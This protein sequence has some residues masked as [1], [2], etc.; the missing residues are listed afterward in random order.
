MNKVLLFFLAVCAPSVITAFS[1]IQHQSFL[2]SASSQAAG[3]STSL[4]AFFKGKEYNKV[5]EN[6]MLTKGLTREEAEQDYNAYLE[7]PTN[8]ALSKV[9]TL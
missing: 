4:N 8:Y 6:L 1:G 9:R 3:T 7:N 5:V 2:I